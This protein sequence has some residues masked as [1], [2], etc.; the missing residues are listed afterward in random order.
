V[1]CQEML[2]YVRAEPFQPFRLHMASGRTFD[3]RHPAMIRVGRSSVIVFDFASE[4]EKVYER[5]EMLGLLL[6][7]SIE[8]LDGRTTPNRN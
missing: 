6:I 8:L 5:V 4:E 1:T 3:V 7:E 2:G